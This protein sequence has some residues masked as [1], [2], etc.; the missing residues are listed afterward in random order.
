[1]VRLPGFLATEEIEAIHRICQA[2][3]YDEAIEYR[4]SSLGDRSNHLPLD[5]WKVLFLHTEHYLRD[6]LPDLAQRLR[7]AVIQVDSASGWGLVQ[8]IGGEERMRMRCAEYHSYTQGAGLGD[9]GHFDSGSLCTIDIML[10]RP[11]MDFEGGYFS[12]TEPDGTVATHSFER[13]DA[14]VFVSHKKH[15]VTPVTSGR[16]RVLVVEFWSGPACICP[17]RCQVAECPMTVHNKRQ[18]DEADFEDSFF[19]L[20]DAEVVGSAMRALA[21]DQENG[22]ENE[23]EG[24]EHNACCRQGT[25]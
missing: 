23:N 10:E 14:V 12:T 8:Q 19:A 1:M 20:M 18:L 5:S 15:H 2:F 11:D 7:E 17:H 21:V 25:M 6:R 24:S 13:G 22:R 4:G 9:P 3:P 16:R